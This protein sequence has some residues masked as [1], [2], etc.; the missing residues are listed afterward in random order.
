MFAVTLFDGVCQPSVHHLTDGQLYSIVERREHPVLHTQQEKGDTWV[1][2]DCDGEL[3]VAYR[4]MHP[5][6]PPSV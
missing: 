3:A 5:H 2:L 6:Y 4:K 1:I